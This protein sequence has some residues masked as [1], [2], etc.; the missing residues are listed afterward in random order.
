[1]TLQPL[2]TVN[3]PATL[4]DEQRQRVSDALENAQ[5]V[6]TRRNYAGQLRQFQSWCHQ[7]NYSA[8]PAQSE[9]VAAYVAELADEG[10]SMS[11]IRLAVA[12]IVDAHRHVGLE[13][14]QTAGVSETMRGLSRRIGVGQKQARPLDADALAAIRATALNP[15]RSRGGSL[16][17]EDTALRRGR[18]DIALASVL[19]DAGL[20]ISEAANLRWRDVLDA[21]NNAGLVYIERSKTD[22][23]GEGAYVVVTPETLVALKQLRQDS[24]LMPDADAPVFGLSMS[25]ISRRVDS[26]ARAA[27]LGEGYSGH[28]GR[29]GLAI[30]MTRRGAPLQAVQTHGRWKSPSMP[31]RYTRSEKALEAL[32]WLV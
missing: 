20:R 27:G 9:V 1:M 28:S 15:R 8:L 11:T 32:E 25:Q 13:S 7:E 12:A 16:E 10:K 31:A 6:N 22:Q 5:S 3:A 30:R 26:M 24:G 19:S 4:T 2:Q 21:E 18:L 17:M 29:V 14:P 23:A